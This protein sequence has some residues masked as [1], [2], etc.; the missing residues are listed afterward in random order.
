MAFPPSFGSASWVDV[1]PPPEAAPEYFTTAVLAA[2]GKITLVWG[3]DGNSF[4]QQFNGSSWGTSVPF[5]GPSVLKISE[6][7]LATGGGRL[8]MAHQG[9]FNTGYVL[10][11]PLP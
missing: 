5:H 9:A 1:A 3:T 6:P 4:Y 11:L 8:Y 7:V 2:G 10:R